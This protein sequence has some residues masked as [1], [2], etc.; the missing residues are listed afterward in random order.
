MDD[1][2]PEQIE[3]ERLAA[4]QAAA[5]QL[6]ADDALLSGATPDQVAA[7]GIR[8]GMPRAEALRRLKILTGAE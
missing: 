7:A 3:A 2:T 1:K 8:N 6:A 4:E 5:D